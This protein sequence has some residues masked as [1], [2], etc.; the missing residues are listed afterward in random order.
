M[1]PD[2]PDPELAYEAS[3]YKRPSYLDGLADRL[4]AYEV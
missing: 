2:Y 1:S 4:D 3:D